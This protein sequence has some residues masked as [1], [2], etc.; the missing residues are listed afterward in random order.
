MRKPD[1]QVTGQS[2]DTGTC[3]IPDGAFMD[4]YLEKQLLEGRTP[5]E[6]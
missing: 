1:E 3:G 5:S 2:G 4:V 6:K